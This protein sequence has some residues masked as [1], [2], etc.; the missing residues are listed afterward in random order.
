MPRPRTRTAQDYIVAK[1]AIVDALKPEHRRVVWEIG[2]DAFS[3]TPAYRPA[4]RAA[5]RSAGIIG[6]MKR[7][8]TA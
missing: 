6:G 3:R 1:M 7:T 4:Y 8:Q 2:L 5:K